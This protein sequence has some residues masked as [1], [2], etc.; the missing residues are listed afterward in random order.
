MKRLFKT[1]LD[2]AASTG[3]ILTNSAKYALYCGY[4]WSDHR[5]WRLGYTQYKLRYLSDLL[6]DRE[7][8]TLFRKGERLPNRFGWRLDARVVEIPWVLAHLTN[9]DATILDAGSSLNHLEVLSSPPLSGRDV[10][11]MTLA[12]ERDCFWKRGTSYV[13]GDLRRLQFKDESFD[14]TICISTIE[15]IGMDNSY[16]TQDT[17]SAR[18]GAAH[19]FLLAVRELRRVLRRG[20]Q[21]Y[22]SFPFGKHENHGWFQ[23]FDAEL[24]D[25]LVA[26]FNPSRLKESVFQ[27]HADGWQV[28]SRREASECQF[29]DVRKSRYFDPTSKLDFPTHCPAGE[30]AVMCLELTR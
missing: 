3:E 10:T 1:G 23:Q 8:M 24:A 7:T 14:A 25:R 12:P 29:F 9:S 26:E 18:P 4:K 11:I 17:D 21:A 13:F 20:R 19:E 16:Y 27:Y 30:G 5:P 2:L 22:F 28:S 6:R 15:H